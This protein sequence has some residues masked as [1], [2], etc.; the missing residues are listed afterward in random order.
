M[1]STITFHHLIFLSQESITNTIIFLRATT[2]WFV[3]TGKD[4]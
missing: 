1:A 2:G 3:M 4:L